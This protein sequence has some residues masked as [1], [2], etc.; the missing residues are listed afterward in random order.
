MRM[1]PLRI[2]RIREIEGRKFASF[3]RFAGI[4]SPEHR[5]VGP[6]DPG[7][8]VKS[9]SATKRYPGPHLFCHKV[10]RL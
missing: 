1:D 10:G 5:P 7:G 4:P 3:A 8:V 9:R 6:A 2:L